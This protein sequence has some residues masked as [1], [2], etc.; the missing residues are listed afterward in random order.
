MHIAQ[1]VWKH[2]GGGLH[3]ATSPAAAQNIEDADLVLVFGARTMLEGADLHER[4]RARHPR[5]EILLGSTAG[6]IHGTRVEDG[7]A[8]STAVR[9]KGTSV[10]GARTELRNGDS[11]AAGK[12]LARRLAAPDLV[13]VFVLSD[14]L[15]VNGT[16]LIAGLTE[17]LPDG[18]QVTGGLAGDGGDFT[19]T[20]VGLNETPVPGVIAAIGFYGDALRVGHGSLGGWDPFGPERKVTRSDGN[21]L[22]ELDGTSALELYRRYLGEHAAGLPGS[23]LLFPLSIRSPDGGPSLVRT[24]LGI[25]D[26]QQSMTFAGDIPEGWMARLMRA[27]FDRLIDG[28]SDAARG[29]QETLRD[30]RA[31]LA[32]LISCVGRK[33]VLGQRTEEEVEGVRE[34]L[35]EQAV[36]CG[37]YSYGE[38]SPVQPT[39][40]CEL[41]NQ[42]MTITT[43]RE[44]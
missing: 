5:A 29:S 7:T 17:E 13:H 33:M 9:F 34:V 12:E 4:L 23:A 36:L 20:L 2:G 15:Q 44:A 43:L 30:G 25:D 22:Y 3:E 28:A 41:H 14:G 38:I 26:E 1:T 31:E 27:N 6:E 16:A 19:R 24:I 10:R 42:T 32:V 40:R 37:F 39:A 21:I 18:V 11:S 35:G 8:V